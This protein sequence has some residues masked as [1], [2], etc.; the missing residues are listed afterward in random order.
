MR[1]R[2]LVDHEKLAFELD[3]ALTAI[4][5]AENSEQ[6]ARDYPDS[7][8]R[9]LA[10]ARASRIRANDHLGLYA[11]VD[12]YGVYPERVIDAAIREKVAHL[13]AHAET[14]TELTRYLHE[15]EDPEDLW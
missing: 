2:L 6:M 13:V 11:Y 8:K 10:D 9:Y 3:C 15:D 4:V 12:A 7:A 1:D 5:S 14:V